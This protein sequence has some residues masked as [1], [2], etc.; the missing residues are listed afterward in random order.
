MTRN[1]ILAREDRF[2]KVFEEALLIKQQAD[3]ETAEEVVYDAN[4]AGYLPD[5]DSL[6]ILNRLNGYL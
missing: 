5:G 6:Y 3:L 4:L 1:T 2:R